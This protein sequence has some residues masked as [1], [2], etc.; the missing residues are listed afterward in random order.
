MYESIIGNL[1]LGI[2]WNKISREY[3]D[4][5]SLFF[6]LSLSSVEIQK[7]LEYINTLK[8]QQ[9]P[10]Y[11]FIRKLFKDGL[12]KRGGSDDGKNIKFTTGKVGSPSSSA[13]A[14]T[15][16]NGHSSPEKETRD[17]AAQQRPAAK[18]TVRGMLE[19]KSNPV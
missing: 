16:C 8:Y 5:C 3:T 11:E 7:Y 4:T 1:S 17:K 18:V 12:K 9:E 6:S 13:V 2:I 10:D 14:S 19:R 15:L